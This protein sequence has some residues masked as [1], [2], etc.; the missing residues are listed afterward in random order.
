M[1]NIVLIATS[2]KE[3]GICTSKELLKIL[4]AIKP[5]VIFEELSQ[6][7]FTSIYEG[8][9]SD[10]LETHAIK[11]Y[12]NEQIVKHHPVDVDGNQLIDKKLKNSI[13]NM[14]EIFGR[15][16]NYQNLSSTL[17]SLSYELG[18][19]FLNSIQYETL[20]AQKYFSEQRLAEFFKEGDLVAVHQTWIRINDFREREMLN[21]IYKYSEIN[22][23]DKAIF[24]V[25][26]EHR[27]PIID[28]INKMEI[29]ARVKM[30]WNF[31]YF[32]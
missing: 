10:S 31:Q 29:E 22:D 2:H 32:H 9:L 20:L 18:F 13:S 17:R 25:G 14:F 4:H 27:K 5:D 19:P 30:N 1:C 26:A 11:L 15:N 16:L 12:S 23:F 6:Q 7:S 21:N 8:R 3:N 24:L 28:M